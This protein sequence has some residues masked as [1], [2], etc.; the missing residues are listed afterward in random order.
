MGAVM[1]GFEYAFG[2]VVGTYWALVFIAFTIRTF[3]GGKRPPGKPIPVKT[4]DKGK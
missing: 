4:D 3:R 2:A 1:A